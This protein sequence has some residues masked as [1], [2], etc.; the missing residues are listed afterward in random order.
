MPARHGRG[1]AQGARLAHVAGSAPGPAG[2]PGWPPPRS[3][4]PGP[5][6]NPA[7]GPGWP[8]AGAAAVTGERGRRPGNA[9]RN[10]DQ[11][12]R[13]CAVSG[14]TASWAACSGSPRFCERPAIPSLA[15]SEQ[16]RQHGARL[17]LR[18]GEPAASPAPE[19]I[20]LRRSLQRANADGATSSAIAVPKASREAESSPAATAHEP[21]WTASA[22]CKCW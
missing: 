14:N 5:S 1:Q 9:C 19:L 7:A 8:V 10:A 16:A 17:A 11:R 4:C 20:K 21:C 12:G 22:L 15:V 13:Q 6:G 3:P 18:A 2:K